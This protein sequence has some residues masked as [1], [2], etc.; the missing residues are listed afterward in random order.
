M[1]G[2]RFVFDRERLVLGWKKFDCKFCLNEST[3]YIYDHHWSSPNYRIL[4]KYKFWSNAGYDDEDSD[5]FEPRSVNYSSVP[6]AGASIPNNITQFG[7]LKRNSAQC[8]V[9][10]S[11]LYMYNIF[12]S[13]HSLLTFLIFVFRWS[14]YGPWYTL[15]MIFTSCEPSNIVG[16]SVNSSLDCKRCDLW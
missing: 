9:A 14:V 11:S 10:P 5:A 12:G 4:V 2:Y 15:L 13:V 6:S 3:H 7:E 16:L 1:T 8:L